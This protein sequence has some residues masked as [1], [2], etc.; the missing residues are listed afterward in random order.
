MQSMHTHALRRALR[1]LLIGLAACLWASAP[2]AQS[3]APATATQ[4]WGGPYQNTHIPFEPKSLWD[5]LRWQLGRLCATRSPA[6]ALGAAPQVPPDLPWLHR[7]AQAGEAMQPSVTWIGHA[8]V[9]AQLGGLNL[10]TDPMFSRRASPVSF[11]GPQRLVPP[12]LALHE[13]PHIDVVLI[14]HNHYDHLDEDSVVALNHQAGGPPLFVVPMGNAAWMAQRG[15][16][17]VV[18]LAWWQQRRVGAVQ[19]VLTP[20]QHWSGRSLTD[21]MDT[22]WGG[23]AVLA[24]DQHLFFAGDTAYSPDFADIRQHFVAQQAG[25]GFDIALI[26]IGAYEPRWFMA[27]QHVDPAQA[28]QIHRDLGARLSLGVHWGTFDLSDEAPDQPPVDL[29]TAREQQA[30]ASDSFFVMAVGQTRV[31]P[32]R[33]TPIL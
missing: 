27:N 16:H 4:A 32:R 21:R 12:G 25:R 28:V 2:W 5:V 6:T 8:T 11:A 20:A 19:V 13:L 22:L 10:L 24:P 30:V 17:N 18:E 14:S 31:L 1:A 23:Y 15:I 7:N 33:G 3:D 29:T 26:P 9:L